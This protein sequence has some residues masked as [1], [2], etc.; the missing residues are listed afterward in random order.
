MKLLSIGLKYF[1]NDMM[2]SWQQYS[3]L[4]FFAHRVRMK[5]PQYASGYLHDLKS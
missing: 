2:L 4:Q 1:P 3:Y 5:P